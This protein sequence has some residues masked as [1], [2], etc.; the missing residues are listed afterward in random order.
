M[1]RIGW[2]LVSAVTFAS[3]LLLH[4]PA[5]DVF[6]GFAR[7]YGFIPYDRTTRAVFVAAGL[8]LWL[9]LWQSPPPAR[10]AIR[11]A[12]VVLTLVLGYT[13]GMLTV[14]G[15]EAIHL[16]QYAL[17]TLMLAAAR[18]KLES[19]WL[20]ATLL[21]AADELWQWQLLR[22]ARP[23]YFDWNDV[24]LNATGAALGALIVARRGR[25]PHGSMLSARVAGGLVA[26]AAGMATLSGPVIDQPFY[27]F[28]PA[29][30][31]FHL[32]SAFESLVLIA[33]LWW[34]VRTVAWRSSGAPA[35]A[36]APEIDHAMPHRP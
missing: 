34:A 22:R 8:V 3:F 21:G 1:S 35:I 14:N 23:E 25:P 13:M 16:P 15:I 24:V 29:G 11:R 27:R 30:R 9:W 36:A 17:L 12:L 19:T 7:R 32:A 28:S 26:V 4:L 20:L 31:W 18:P 2:A 33:I 6:D 10:A 5:S